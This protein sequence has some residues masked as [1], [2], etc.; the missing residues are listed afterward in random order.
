MMHTKILKISHYQIKNISNSL[1]TTKNHKKP[2]FKTYHNLLSIN[3]L[4]GF[5]FTTKNHNV[6][7]M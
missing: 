6:T 7:T 3:C 4:I 2:Q 5:L 1:F